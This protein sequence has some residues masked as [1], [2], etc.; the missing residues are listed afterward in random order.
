MWGASKMSVGGSYRG[1][2]LAFL[3][4]WLGIASDVRCEEF[5]GDRS[6]HIDWT[7]QQQWGDFGLQTVAAAPG[8]L[9]SPLRI[10]EK[11]VRARTRAS[12]QR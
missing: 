3:L 5:L 12:R 11:D 6:V 8:A 4:G 2:L 9:G 7:H 1:V 10:G